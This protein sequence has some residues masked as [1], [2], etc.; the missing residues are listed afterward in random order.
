LILKEHFQI[1][2]ADLVTYPSVYEGFGNALLE[3]IYFKKLLVINRYPVYNADI[4]PLGF[5]FIELDGY[6]DDSV[7]KETR[8]LLNDKVTVSEMT[9][10]NYN[11]A[12]DNF[13][14]EILQRKLGDL[15]NQFGV[16]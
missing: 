16:R 3:S 8:Y 5:K 14:L 4:R 12:Q 6:I 1:P 13:S 15:L 7:V 9:E 10:Q 11:I 2:H